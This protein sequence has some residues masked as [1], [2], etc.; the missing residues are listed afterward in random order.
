MMIVTDGCVQL[1][2]TTISLSLNL[3]PCGIVVVSHNN[4]AVDMSCDHRAATVAVLTGSLSPLL[5]HFFDGRYVTDKTFPTL[6]ALRHADSSMFGIAH[7]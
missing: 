4:M 7:R 1:L 3:P 6:P 2:A 5:F